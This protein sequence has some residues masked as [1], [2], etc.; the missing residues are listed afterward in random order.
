VKLIAQ[1]QLRPTPEQ[2]DAL[3]RTLEVANAAAND[4][5][6]HAWEHRVFGQYEL[7]KDLYYSIKARYDLTAQM[8]VRL[9]AKVADAYKMDRTSKRTFRSHGSIAYDD[10]ILRWYPDTVSIWTVTGRLR[11]PFVC[12]DRQRE[13]LA[14]RQ[15]ESDLVC[16]DGKWYLLATCE[17]P[18]QPQGTPDD[19]LGVD[20]G[21]KNIAVTSDGDVMSGGRVRGLRHR[22]HRLRQR[23][24]S[25][26]TKSA[27]RLLKKRRRKEARFQ[28][29]VN[30]CISK[31]IV[32][33]AERSGRGI[34]LEDLKGIRTRVS[35]RKPQRRTLHSWA[36]AQL[37]S[38][39]EYKARRDGVSV[40]VV[41][42]RNTSRTCPVCEHCEKANRP[43][44]STFSCRSCGFSGF[45]DQ[46][47]ATNIRGRASVMVPHA[48]PPGICKPTCF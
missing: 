11:M 45:A 42:P 24:Q 32:R 17:V 36:F 13:M 6:V 20:L 31:R 1:V 39:I 25:K 41:D 38:Y 37:R 28:R 27:K 19:W 29:D 21:A 34:A 5:S 23:L 16:A 8:V 9:I 46:I 3:R 18:E 47:A 15:G 14:F 26:G 2:A 40:V 48:E 35:A 30:H 43:N 33:E 44:Q 4:I 7:H 12:A 22:H 10:R